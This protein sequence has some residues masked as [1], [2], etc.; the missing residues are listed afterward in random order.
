MVLHFSESSASPAKS[1]Q[2]QQPGWEECW[3]DTCSDCQQERSLPA[4]AMSRA[5]MFLISAFAGRRATCSHQPAPPPAPTSTRVPGEDS[6]GHC[7]ISW[8]L[9]LPV[10][11]MGATTCTWAGDDHTRGPS[12]TAQHR[13]A[14]TPWPW[15]CWQFLSQ[16]RELAPETVTSFSPHFAPVTWTQV[17]ERF[18]A[19][20]PLGLMYRVQR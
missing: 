5:G 3:S 4:P 19:L 11:K 15:P 7:Q 18:L 12:P 13:W 10:F 2:S 1:W 20:C 17:Q 6:L 14:L 9:R 8:S 16:S